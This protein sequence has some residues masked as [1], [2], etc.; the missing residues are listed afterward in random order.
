MSVWWDPPKVP[1]VP[2]QTI[3]FFVGV[4][5]IHLSSRPRMYGCRSIPSMTRVMWIVSL[6]WVSLS[7]LPGP[8]MVP[9]VSFMQTKVL[10]GG[11]CRQK[12]VW[13]D[14]HLMN[15]QSELDLN[16]F[17]KG[18]FGTQRV[19]PQ[20]KL[21]RIHLPNLW[22]G[23]DWWVGK[24]DGEEVGKPSWQPHKKSHLHLYTPKPLE[25]WWL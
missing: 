13:Y 4:P 16:C 7:L 17:F 1:I 15:E 10:H 11:S 19:P 5:E 2:H 14:Q 18:G 20:K 22:V 21:Y 25:F 8:W 6:L 23:G 24:Q 12:K 3:R 9:Y